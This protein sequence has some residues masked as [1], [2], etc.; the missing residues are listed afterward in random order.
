MGFAW[1]NRKEHGAAKAAGVREC[2]PLLASATLHHAP[3]AGGTKGQS[4]LGIAAGIAG[5]Q[6]QH[7]RQRHELLAATDICIISRLQAT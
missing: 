2:R 5:Q 4:R 7:Q 3:A 1:Q 6:Q